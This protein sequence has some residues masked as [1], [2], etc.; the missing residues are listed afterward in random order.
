MIE[1]RPG[2]TPSNVKVRVRE[3]YLTTNHGEYNSDRSLLIHDGNF[4]IA[5]KEC[6]ATS[7]RFTK[8][9]YYPAKAEAGVFDNLSLLSES[10]LKTIIPGG[11]IPPM[12]TVEKEN[13][14][15][16]LAQIQHKQS[17]YLRQSGAVLNSG[18]DLIDIVAVLKG[19]TVTAMPLSSIQTKADSGESPLYIK[20][21]PTLDNSGQITSFHAQTLQNL[22]NAYSRT[23]SQRPTKNITIPR[24]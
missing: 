6:S 13:M 5:C 20:L 3:S 4:E 15:V 18:P 7:F 1:D 17:I 12:P 21:K 23:S 16:V 14:D 2:Q 19:M 22:Q 8:E 10:E 24:K 11:E 9:G